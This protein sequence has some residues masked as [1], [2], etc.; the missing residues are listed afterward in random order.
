MSARVLHQWPQTCEA[1][2][3]RRYKAGERLK[4][5]AWQMERPERVVKDAIAR[6]RRAGRLAPRNPPWTD[7]EDALVLQ[8]MARAASQ[9]EGARELADLLGRSADTIRQ[10]FFFLRRRQ[11][12]AQ[13]AAT[14]LPFAAAPRPMGT[15]SAEADQDQFTMELQAA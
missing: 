8:R 4:C 6:L 14:A 13:A 3:I 1:E 12:E 10:R 5:I 9:M 15:V 11:R 2:L 7:R